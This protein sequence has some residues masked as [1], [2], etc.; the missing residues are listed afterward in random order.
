MPLGIPCC[1]CI[2]FYTTL[3]MSGALLFSSSTIIRALLESF[4]IRSMILVHFSLLGN[5]NIKSI[6]ITSYF[7]VAAEKFC[8]SP[9]VL[10]FINFGLWYLS[11]SDTSF[12]TSRCVLFQNYFALIIKRDFR[13]YVCP[14]CIEQ[15]VSWRTG[16]CILLSGM[17]NW[18]S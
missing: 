1:L 9:C 3:S 17:Q 7:L 5:W 10:L 14:P 11:H 18:F 16:S 2:S 4:S 13:S 6:D 15:W 8:S 12:F